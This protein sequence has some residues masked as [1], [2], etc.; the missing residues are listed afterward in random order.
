MCPAGRPEAVGGLVRILRFTMPLHLGGVRPR[1]ALVVLL[2]TLPM[3]VFA[4]HS[5][6]EDRAREQARA[7]TDAVRL[8]RVVGL[9]EKRLF[10]Q[11]R[12]LLIDLAGR[13]ATTAGLTSE[14]HGGLDRTRGA[15]KWFDNLAVI[16]LD[17]TAVCSAD[18]LTGDVA[19]REHFVRALET[20]GF[21][22]GGYER[23]AV[24]DR[25]ILNFAYP[26][27]DAEGRP[28]LVV[29]ATMDLRRLSDFEE[30]IR[31][32]LPPASTVMKMD[33]DA[34]ILAMAPYVAE[35]VG[36]RPW[37]IEALRPLLARGSGSAVMRDSSGR[38]VLR[39]V[40]R[41]PYSLYGGDVFV[42]LDMPG[43]V[44]FAD[45]DAALRESLFALT[46]LVV[47]VLGATWLLA[48]VII[49]RPV[50]DLTRAT[51]RVAAGEFDA[52]L[53]PPYP[54]GELGDLARR[55]D[56]MASTV[57]AREGD[58]VRSEA[59]LRSFVDRAPYGIFATDAGGRLMA[60]NP[61]FARLLG[62]SSPGDLTGVA[63]EDLCDPTSCGCA[64]DGKTAMC[65]TLKL[66]II[67]KR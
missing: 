19:G 43:E 14:C 10:G 54:A 53:G 44:A 3:F 62:R 32:L 55:F 57:R 12:M 64:S 15:F 51:E 16:R 34:R 39:A 30:S 41:A 6:S 27:L 23:D 7:I 28:A 46:G 9:E 49:S 58:L 47:L 65:T 66:W 63:L 42:V 45:V 35:R 8:A 24:T 59:R 11:V 33:G 48:T 31:T 67:I 56:V 25:A 26:V 1:L 13:V 40:A 61:A 22:F 52:R 17:G 4:L 2:A 36:T 21:A 38:D 5:A 20:R 37:G 50:R 29:S 18:P 60:A